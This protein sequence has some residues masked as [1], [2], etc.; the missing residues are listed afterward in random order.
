M[1]NAKKAVDVKVL[2]SAVSDFVKLYGVDIVTKSA[3]PDKRAAEKELIA[4][5]KEQLEAYEF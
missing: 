2:Q 1:A 5:I 3:L 4:V